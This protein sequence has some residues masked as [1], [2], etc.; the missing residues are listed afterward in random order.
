MSDYD[1]EERGEIDWNEPGLKP[2]FNHRG[3]RSEKLHKYEKRVSDL[4]ASS[5]PKEVM[6]SLA[7]DLLKLIS[8]PWLLFESWNFLA[9]HNGQAPGRDGRRFS[10]YSRDEVGVLV[11]ELSKSIRDDSYLPDAERLKRIDK[12]NGAGKRCLVIQS[13]VDRVVQRAAFVVLQPLFDKLFLA[14]SFGF[15]PNRGRLHALATIEQQIASKCQK[16]WLAHDIRDAY[17]HVRLPQL[18]ELL[19]DYLPDQRLMAFLERV[20]VS[21]KVNGLRQGGPLSPLMFNFYLHHLLD[22]PWRAKC[23]DSVLVRYADNLH[24]GGKDVESV[25]AHDQTLRSLLTSVGMKFKATCNEA[26][27]DLSRGDHLEFLGYRVDLCD[28][29]F[30]VQILNQSRQRLRQKFRLAHCKN[31]SQLRADC[32][33]RGW[34][35]SQ[36]PAYSSCD[37]GKICRRIHHVARDFGFEEITSVEELQQIWAR[38]HTEWIKLRDSLGVI[39]PA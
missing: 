16:V 27:K 2:L 10:T 37:P 5:D 9:M 34:L 1:W 31:D 32:I 36:A 4:M 24:C 7:P 35:N 13:I 28:G 3:L 39:D 23:P 17:G 14:E 20:L 33:A 12:A 18:F 15:R 29:Q 30:R 11:A 8:E 38:A 25:V 19:R 22:L 6:R 21:R 26:V